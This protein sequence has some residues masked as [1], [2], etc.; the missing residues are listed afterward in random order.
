MAALTVWSRFSAWSNTTEAGD[1]KTSSVTSVGLPE[2]EIG[3][4]KMSRLVGRL[5]HR[6]V[7]AEGIGQTGDGKNQPHPV[8]RCGEHK[9]AAGLPGP[10]SAAC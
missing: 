7:N 1:S 4:P 9:V 8:L 2:S 3:H 6:G 5:F 10:P